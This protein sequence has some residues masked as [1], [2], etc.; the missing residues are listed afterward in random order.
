MFNLSV[1]TGIVTGAATGI[2][3][4]IAERLAAAGATIAIAD[5]DLP[6][7]TRAACSIGPS[8]FPVETDVSSDESI[9]RTVDKVLERTQQIDI[10]VN[11]AGI[12]G[13][14]APIWEQQTEDWEKIAASLHC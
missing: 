8:A 6:G 2:G 3:K 9:R 11:N 13:S 14:A 7:A 5:L 12:A 4:A 1:Q 10:L